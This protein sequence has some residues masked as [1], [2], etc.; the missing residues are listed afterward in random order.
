MAYP[1]DG[2]TILLEVLRAV[3]LS[4]T[5]TGGSLG[6]NTTPVTL[7]KNTQ[8][9]QRRALLDELACLQCLS[10]CVARSPE[11]G[12]RLGT[13]TIGLLPL[14]AAATG[15]GIR[16][17][18]IA[19][20]LLTAACD[21]NTI[22]NGMQKNVAKGHSAVSEALSTLRLRCGEPVRFRLLVGMLNSGGG[23]GE[24]QAVGLRFVN[25]FLESA[26]TTQ[27]RLYLQAE[28]FQAGFDP[29][30]MTKTIT[31]TS[32]WLEKLRGEVRR[33]DEKKIDIGRL[34][35]QA[36]EAEK[37]RGQLVVLERRCLILQEEKSVLTSMERRL[38]ERCAELQREVFRLQGTR[39]D[40]QT[41]DGIEQRPIALPRQVPPQNKVE[42]SEHDD[43]GI[44]SSETGP[45]LSPEPERSFPK[46]KSQILKIHCDSSID[47]EDGNTTIDDVIEELNN[48]VNDAER[49]IIQEYGSQPITTN[50]Y[51][52]VPVNLLPQPPRKSRSLVHL[53]SNPSEADGSDYGLLL[54]QDNSKMTFF[55]ENDYGS[56]RN[57]TPK[58]YIDDIKHEPFYNGENDEN[59]QKLMKD[60]NRAIL[61]VIMDARE[62]GNQTPDLNVSDPSNPNN[63]PAPPQPPA[64]HFNGVFFMS[65]MNS[66][67]RYPKPDLSAALEAKRVTKNLDRMETYGL[68]SMVDIVF[69]SDKS[70][71]NFVTNKAPPLKFRPGYGGAAGM[72]SGHGGGDVAVT[73]RSRDQSSRTV[74]NTAGSKVTD[75]PSG[76][77]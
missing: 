19:L 77:Y 13:T 1:L 5:Q 76:L 43:E 74:S 31:S 72:Y 61:N 23:T 22:A 54:I 36:R 44:S 29:S 56:E 9:Y 3:Q 21:K 41:N 52:I 53:L 42:T 17:R 10:V 51:E 32:P 40:I 69:T 24:F 30:T 28:L 2:T 59:N 67:Q 39:S 37:I 34:Q 50:E 68:D 35:L 57:S 47:H 38:Q 62:K 66:P 64:Q 48:I 12:A 26:D 70:R 6:P 16:S 7:Q 75:L 71:S 49:E 8:S 60:S 65:E 55:D 20:Q 4:Q 58:V 14:A 27:T 11:A 25:T 45:S 15:Q 63:H 73:T 33:W 46:D 18:I